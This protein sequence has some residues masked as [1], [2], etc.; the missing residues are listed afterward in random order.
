MDDT[1]LV[2]GSNEPA[3]VRFHMDDGRVMGSEGVSLLGRSPAARDD[4]PVATLVTLADS[5]VS[6]THLALRIEGARAWV[7][8]RA[9]TNGT[10]LVTS[11]G[12]ERRLVPWEE[13]PVAPGEALHVGTSV[14][15]VELDRAPGAA[16]L[17]RD[18]D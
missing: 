14:L 16:T 2:A 5:A 15:R 18:G 17:S 13:T 11:A 9:S 6:K 8:D 1:R 4:E 7:T 10:L 12:E 3:R